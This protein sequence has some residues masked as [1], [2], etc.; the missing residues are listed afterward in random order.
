MIFL[1]IGKVLQ[2][3]GWTHLDLFLTSLQVMMA[4]EGAMSLLTF[5]HE[6]VFIDSVEPINLHFHSE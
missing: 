2:F 6:D 1:L 5:A 4:G 3:S